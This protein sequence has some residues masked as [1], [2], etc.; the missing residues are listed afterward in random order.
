MRIV[1]GTHRGRKLFEPKGGDVTRPTADRV[2]EACASVLES[3]LP[4]G[5]AG[6]SA[7]DAFA[8]TGA[9]GLEMVSR[10]ARRVTFFD[11][12]RAA[13]ALVRKNVGLLGLSPDVATVVQADVLV[14]AHRGSVPG[15]PFSIVLLDP[16]YAFGT[17]PVAALLRDLASGGLL[18]PGAIVLFERSGKIDALS[19]EGF[20]YLREKRYGKTNVDV[21]RYAPDA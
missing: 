13:S 10:G 8:G 3:A 14:S 5:I 18:A 1:G 15:A 2:R 12:D 21:L 6:A 4:D 17:E 7:L 20:E 16:P 9:F 19:V 11:A